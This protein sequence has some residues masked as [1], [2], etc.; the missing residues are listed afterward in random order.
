MEGT[1]KFNLPEER[2]ELERA[3]KADKIFIEVWDFLAN[4]RRYLSEEYPH[5]EGYVKAQV[6][7]KN[8][9]LDRGIDIEIMGQ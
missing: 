4:G 1:L 3:M 8:R 9:L 5:Y 7:L 2:V 6:Y